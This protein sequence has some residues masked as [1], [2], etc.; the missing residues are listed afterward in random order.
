M[1]SFINKQTDIQKI[2][3]D[4]NW[5]VSSYTKSLND[6]N[7][8]D[9]IYQ[10]FGSDSP[11]AIDMA[12]NETTV[13]YLE[14]LLER[15][16]ASDGLRL[17]F[18]ILLWRSTDAVKPSRKQSIEQRRD[19]VFSLVA[20]YSSTKN[21]MDNEITLLNQGLTLFS[22]AQQERSYLSYQALF[23]HCLLAF[24]DEDEYDDA[25]FDMSMALIQIGGE[26][27]V[28]VQLWALKYFMEVWKS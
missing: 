26:N 16:G 15:P 28:Q 11:I 18:L 3:D 6:I 27:L 23:Q 13:L 21:D 17:W 5:G 9:S 14:R 25:E 8:I 7:D 2:L 10:T 12:S 1:K 20:T 24:I 19:L 4:F 22:Q